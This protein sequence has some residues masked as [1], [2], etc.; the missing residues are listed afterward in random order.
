MQPWTGS[1]TTP[2]AWQAEV[3][4]L[5]L[6]YLAAPSPEKGKAVCAVMGAGKSIVQAEVCRLAHA[7]CPDQAIVVVA[8]KT[9]LVT[10]LKKTI[11]KVCGPRVSVARY[12][13][14]GKN[15]RADVIVTTTNSLAKLGGVLKKWGRKTR[16]LIIDECHRSE[17]TTCLQGAAEV[18]ASHVLGFSAT[19]WR[20]KLGERL[21][22][23]DDLLYSYSMADALRDGVL[24]PPRLHLWTDEDQKETG[25]VAGDD[26]AD[27]VVMHW[28]KTAA[29][30]CL[31]SAH[32]IDDAEAFA[33]RIN[34]ELGIS[35]AAVHSRVTEADQTAIIERVES[36]DLDA[37]VH[38]SLLSEGVDIP[39][40][41]SLIMRRR[42]SSSIRYPQEVG[43]VLRTDPAGGKTY[44]DVYDPHAASAVLS[45]DSEA[46][47]WQRREA[48]VLLPDDE[49]E[50]AELEK[51]VDTKTF[52]ALY[53]VSDWQGVL[54]AMRDHCCG[55]VV[56][57]TASA[58]D[59]GQRDLIRATP[60]EW[61]SEERGRILAVKPPVSSRFAVFGLVEDAEV[62]VEQQRTVMDHWLKSSGRELWAEP[63]TLS[64][65]PALNEKTL[66]AAGLIETPLSILM[67]ETVP[68]EV[69]MVLWRVSDLPQSTAATIDGLDRR[70]VELN[71][72]PQ[73]IPG[74]CLT[75]LQ[76]LLHKG[77]VVADMMGLCPRFTLTQSQRQ[78]EMTE[79][80]AEMIS[81]L[82]KGA[83]SWGQTVPLDDRAK[84]REAAVSAARGGLLR[85]E[86]S[87]FIAL[88]TASNTMDCWIL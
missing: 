78:Y 50:R 45:L 79:K 86:A 70:V 17:S 54:T 18:A 72:E 11:S 26:G 35:A 82:V 55:L 22:L 84:L 87:D 38:V 19:P 21:T 28:L 13:G 31:V 47:L 2:R 52:T 10:Q 9:R 42:V 43:R 73:L 14:Y 5:I 46:A 23:F 30:P 69:M 85:G 39:A 74:A 40:L 66:K 37:L 63:V 65:D 3:L 16:L 25:I 58:L 67:G 41:R 64:S 68:P 81:D 7:T 59:A 48:V 88:L 12:D 8:P 80:Q 27:A 36:G 44:A 53:P 61:E 33:A 56:L 29:K 71:P 34:N 15:A 49:A 4:P 24:V 6:D 75:P 83:A 57:Y 62:G 76:A 20:A 51:W 60:A 32:S 77:A 1:I